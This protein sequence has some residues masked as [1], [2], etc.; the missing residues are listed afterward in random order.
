MRAE[1]KRDGVALEVVG[2][3]GGRFVSINGGHAVDLIRL[4]QAHENWMPRL[5]AGE[6]EANAAQ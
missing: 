4:K 5:M 2:L 3:A 1:A 6:P